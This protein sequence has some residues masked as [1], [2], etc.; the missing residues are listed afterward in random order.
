MQT[1]HKLEQMGLT[2]IKS[3]H[4]GNCLYDAIAGQ[5]GQ[6]PQALRETLHHFLAQFF[7]APTPLVFELLDNALRRTPIHSSMHDLANF[8]LNGRL[9]RNGEWGEL[10][11]MPFIVYVLNRPIILINLSSTLTDQPHL[12][13]D[14]DLSFTEI[15]L[16]STA[17]Y[18]STHNAIV[19]IFADDAYYGVTPGLAQEAPDWQRSL[20]NNLAFLTTPNP[21]CSS[22]SPQP[23][24]P[25]NGGAYPDNP[26]LSGDIQTSLSDKEDNSPFRY[27][28]IRQPC[29][30]CH[31]D[32]KSPCFRITITT[33]NT[34]VEGFPIFYPV[35]YLYYLAHQIAIDRRSYD[36]QCKINT[37]IHSAKPAKTQKQ[38][39]Q[40]PGIQ[41]RIHKFNSGV[42]TTGTADNTRQP[43]KNFQ[44]AVKK[45]ILLIRSARAFDDYYVH[46]P[47]NKAETGV[48]N[49]YLKYLAKASGEYFMAFGNRH[50][51]IGAKKHIESKNKSTKDFK[52]KRKTSDLKVIHSLIPTTPS[53]SKDNMKS[54]F[55]QEELRTSLLKD[56]TAGLIGLAA[57]TLTDNE[58]NDLLNNPH[59]TVETT[60]QEE[61]GTPLEIE[62]T[63]TQTD[64][65]QITFVLTRSYAEE[66]WDVYRKKQEELV[67]VEVIT[68]SNGRIVTADLDPLFI[69]FKF[70]RLDLAHHDKL[71]LPL[72]TNLHT[73]KRIKR[74][75]KIANPTR[76]LETSLEALKT[77]IDNFFM[78][79]VFLPHPPV[80][81]TET[82]ALNRAAINML[83]LLNPQL[84]TLHVLE[85]YWQVLEKKWIEVE[86]IS[87][88]LIRIPREH[89]DMGN[90]N[91]RAIGLVEL[92]NK[93]LGRPDDNPAVHHNHDAH[94]LASNEA[95]NYPADIYLPERMTTTDENNNL[96]TFNKG[97]NHIR[98]QEE[99]K[100]LVQA[101]KDN[102]WYVT[103]NHALWPELSA[104]RSRQWKQAARVIEQHLQ[105]RLKWQQEK[106]K[107]RKTH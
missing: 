95:L 16:N 73:Q 38:P 91:P 22:S 84:P 67:R 14:T 83:I 26:S 50:V 47:T 29:N 106:N 41:D 5:T 18:A 12:L 43:V 65:K 64:G 60:R 81:D 63:E 13:I 56:L 24:L 68:D 66:N 90:V 105:Q 94:S 21:A 6:S 71:P 33:I 54:L 44:A 57:Y 25:F 97:V 28:L 39:L 93:A 9:R 1:R 103:L 23:P 3:R 52:Q 55:F 19:L 78:E 88:Y 35:N 62:M 20:I 32:E 2:L 72:I 51:A 34:E 46:M 30:T 100:R 49:N 76:T 86:G 80:G 87:G 89:P 48:P 102:D 8:Y 10:M 104:I 42:T 98:D 96:I 82:P 7:Q 15:S 75:K 92:M 74:L 36:I 37:L 11:L 107:L 85:K 59:L 17:H 61:D 101:L 58:V 69:S 31:P 99:M 45:I 79:I 27:R 70:E 40:L 53:L 77:G 4:D